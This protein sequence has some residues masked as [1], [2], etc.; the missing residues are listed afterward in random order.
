MKVKYVKQR[1]A[2]FMAAAM[3]LSTVFP[4]MAA[5]Q[6]D[7]NGDRIAFGSGR[8]TVA[9]GSDALASGSDA[10]DPDKPRDRYNVTIENV[11]NG[12][13]A[14]YTEDKEGNQTYLPIGETVELPTGIQ[15]YYHAIGYRGVVKGA[16]GQ[17]VS[18]TFETEDEVTKEENKN[19]STSIWGSFVVEDDVTVIGEFVMEE[20]EKNNDYQEPDYIIN[21]EPYDLDEPGI[22]TGEVY[23]MGKPDY[24]GYRQDVTDE[25]ELRLATKE[26]IEDADHYYDKEIEKFQYDPETKILTSKEELDYGNYNLYFLLTA[27]GKQYLDSVYLSVGTQLNF[28]LNLVAVDGEFTTDGRQYLYRYGEDAYL[29]RNS[30]FVWEDVEEFSEGYNVRM[31]GYEQE[32]WQNYRQEE[33]LP[34]SALEHTGE[35]YIDYGAFALMKN[36][37]GDVYNVEAIYDDTAIPGTDED[38]DED[39]NQGGSHSG[40]SSGGKSSSSIS[41]RNPYFMHGTWSGE[42]SQWRFR[43]SDGSYASN[44]WGYINGAWYYFNSEG[45]MTTG[46]QSIGGKWYYMDPAQGS[47]Q[48]MMKT[49]WVYDNGYNGWFYLE[50]SGAMLTGWQQINGIWYYLNPISDG[51]QGLMAADAWVEGYYVGADG[52]WQE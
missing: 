50:A 39:D 52:A 42:G 31:W 35:H 7:K 34:D 29:P 32:G 41:S 44:E 2:V 47:G 12:C 18:V 22:Y 6:G 40:S 14:A 49:G 27:D 1:L 28:Y 45:Y 25:V 37:D 15:V 38:P 43:N 21:S 48:G 46:W 23:V 51:S 24:R 33:Y 11:K 8:T 26:E 9:S 20:E 10:Q 30:D 3:T 5:V 17:P 36:E 16:Y 19:D 13:I 4:A